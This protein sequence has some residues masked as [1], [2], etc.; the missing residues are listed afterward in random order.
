MDDRSKLFSNLPPEQQAIPDKCFHPPGTFSEF[1]KKE[2]ERSIPKRFE[3]IVQLYPHHQAVQIGVHSLTYKELN[4]AFG[5]IS[6]TICSSGG[7]GLESVMLMCCHA[8]S[9]ISASFGILTANKSPGSFTLPLERVRYMMDK[10]FS[11]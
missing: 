10:V 11:S 7:T 9:T 5:C 2:M 6:G 4:E 1:P 3:K 8:L